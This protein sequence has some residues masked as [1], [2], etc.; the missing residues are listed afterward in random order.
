MPPR[1][2]AIAPAYNIAAM[3]VARYSPQLHTHHHRSSHCD[4]EYTAGSVQN[5]PPD[6]IQTG[7]IS[8]QTKYTDCV[9]RALRNAYATLTNTLVSATAQSIP[10]LRHHVDMNRLL[11]YNNNTTALTRAHHRLIDLYTSYGYANLSRLAP[12]DEQI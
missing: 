6:Q 1:P 9:P 4:S 10:Q 7:E 2:R 11:Y 8:S 12:W 3:L 5:S